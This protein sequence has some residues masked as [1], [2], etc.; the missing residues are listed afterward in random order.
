MEQVCK[1][2]ATDTQRNVI[3]E[4][5]YSMVWNGGVWNGMRGLVPDPGSLDRGLDQDV[6]F[7]LFRTNHI[8][9]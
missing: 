8:E 1:G 7:P 9:R 4:I 2:N 5:V 3:F 6:R